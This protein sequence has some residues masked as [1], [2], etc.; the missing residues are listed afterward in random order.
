MARIELDPDEVDYIVSLMEEVPQE[1]VDRD[2]YLKFKAL[3]ERFRRRLR[4][5]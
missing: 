5:S 2:V 3:Q 4:K 1:H